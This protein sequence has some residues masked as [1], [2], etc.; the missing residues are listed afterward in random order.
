MNFKSSIYLAAFLL[1]PLSALSQI[2]STTADS[3]PLPSLSDSLAASVVDTLTGDSVGVIFEVVPWQYHAY[4]GA[5]LAA[6]DS[7]LRW[8]LWPSW[9]YKK[10]RDPGVISYRLGTIGRN[11]AQLLDAQEPKYQQLFWEDIRLNDPVSGIANWN[12]IPHHSIQALY[13][14]D[15]GITHDTKF[16]LKEYYL[17]EPLTRFIF[18]ESSF[19]TRSLEFAVSRNFGQ[20]TNAELSFWDRRDGGEYNNSSIVGRQVYARVSHQLDKQQE[21]KLNFLNNN[22]DNELPF[23]YNISNPGTFN[24]DRFNTTAEQPMGN[25][26]QSSTVIKLDYYRRPAD[27]TR[28]TNNLQAGI[29]TNFAGREVTYSADTTSYNVQVLGANIRKCRQV[30]PIDTDWAA[31]YSYFLNKDRASSNL[32]FGNWGLLKSEAKATINA[33]RFLQLGWHGSFRSRS[34]AFGDFNIGARANL[35]IT[36]RINLSAAFS[37]GTRIPAPQQLYWQSNQFQGDPDLLEEKI[38]AISGKLTVKPFAG[39]TVGIKAH[40]KQIEDG[41]VVGDDSTFANANAYSSLSTTGFFD[42]NSTHFEVAG[43]ATIHQFGNFLKSRIQPLPVDETE[44]I[45]F[46]ASAYVKGYLFDRATY[47]KGGFAGVI[48]PQLYQPAQY[49]PALGYWQSSGS[50]FIPSFNRLD[51]DL[52]ARVR[53]II[54]LLRYE[55]VLDN[56]FQQGYFES[57]GYPLTRRRFIFGI[58]VLLRN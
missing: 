46:R 12:Y 33:A 14:N 13:E 16:Y 49:F 31:S 15:T 2:D 55:N 22:Y 53:S 37:S 30:G 23:G 35:S 52:S 48:S 7:T 24:F 40:L 47:V 32:A 19:D 17:N 9:T 41:I 34:D 54:V 10:N 27:S 44:R 6:T 28:T 36:D 1:I 58:R 5:E 4:I 25:G 56:L 8:Q 21:L 51:I 43:S 39:S 42:Y 3:V 57:A 26:S 29:F 50:E 38:Q 18:D 11:N 45:W 20:K